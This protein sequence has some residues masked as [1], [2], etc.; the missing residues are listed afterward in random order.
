MD[1]QFGMKLTFGVT[2]CLRDNQF[3]ETLFW[4][5]AMYC[6]F[7]FLSVLAICGTLFTTTL[8]VFLALPQSQLRDVLKKGQ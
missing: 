4:E 6:L 2:I 1:S 8:V 7:G 3:V 5:I